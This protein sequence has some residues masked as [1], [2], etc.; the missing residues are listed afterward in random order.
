MQNTRV[1]VIDDSA[2]IRALFCDVLDNAKGIEVC[3]VAANA[4]EAR[5]KIAMLKPDVLTLDNE[6]PGMSGLEFLAEIM[7]T[8]PMPVIMLSSLTQAGTGTERRAFELGAAHCFPKPISS[9]KE[10]FNATVANLTEIVTRVANGEV[11][12]DNSTEQETGPEGSSYTSDGSLVVLVSGSAGLDMVKQVL[13][14]YP[15]ECPPTILMLDA[16]RAEAERVVGSMQGTVACTIEPAFDGMKIVRGRACL[17]HNDIGAVTVEPGQIPRLRVLGRDAN[18]ST[19]AD[20]LLTSLAQGKVPALAGLLTGKGEDGAKGLQTLLQAGGKA[21]VQ[22]PP[23]Y[24]PRDRFN[25]VRTLR[26]E[27]KVL[28]QDGIADW[29]LEQTNNA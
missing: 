9:S 3:G 17:V 28:K 18:A 26:L 11:I 22:R 14:S 25:A 10:Q 21:F 19:R 5:D 16:D 7:E 1:M 6:M 24:A 13:A 29:I 15:E 12:N 20:Q 4:D 27:L 8:Q 2:L 23:D